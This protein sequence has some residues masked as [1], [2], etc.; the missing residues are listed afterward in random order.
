MQSI[1]SA[2]DGHNQRH[3][4]SG[5]P[6]SIG[7]RRIGLLGG[8]FNPAHQGHVHISQLAKAKLGLDEI[9]WLVS[10]QNPLKSPTATSALTHRMR[11]A[12]EITSTHRF[13]KIMAPEADLGTRYTLDFAKWLRLRYGNGRFVWL[14][15]ADNLS[16]FH[17]WQGWQQIAQLLPIAVI[18]RPGYRH[19]AVASKAARAL[20]D[21]RW[22]ETRALGLADAAPPA[23]CFL[24]G[25]LSAQS[26]TAIRAQCKDAD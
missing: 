12:K 5:L 3:L 25:P 4:P 20:E 9:W 26:S 17:F 8:S 7:R 24:H 18:D 19:K 13:I 15:G 6:L 2:P 16:G 22:P 10:P 1:F 11:M 21:W 14:M 23:W